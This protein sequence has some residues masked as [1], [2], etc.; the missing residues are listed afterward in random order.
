MRHAQ[1]VAVSVPGRQGQ[2]A[3]IVIKSRSSRD[4]RDRQQRQPRLALRRENARMLP[5]RASHT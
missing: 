4:R 5:M 2:I 1:N 3:I